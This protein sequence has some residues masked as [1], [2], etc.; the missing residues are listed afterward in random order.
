M[1][2][3]VVRL[4]DIADKTGFSTNT[5]SLALRRDTTALDARFRLPEVLAWLDAGATGS[6]LPPLAGTLST[7]RVTL[8]GATLEGVELELDDAP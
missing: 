4:R 7:P 8:D 5:V 1:G 2:R 6:P 3:N